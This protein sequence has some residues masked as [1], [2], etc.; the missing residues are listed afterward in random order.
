MIKNDQ[1]GGGEGAGGT[2]DIAD[3]G[4]STC[5]RC[6]KQDENLETSSVLKRCFF[7]ACLNE[8]FDCEVL[9]SYGSLF[10]VTGPAYEKDL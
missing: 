6:S 8:V 10:Q 9:I 3:S 1:F 2:E 5:N 4:Y 7:R